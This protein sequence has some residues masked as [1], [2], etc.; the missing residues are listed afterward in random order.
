MV[1]LKKLIITLF[2][3]CVVLYYMFTSLY[4]LVKG[5]VTESSNTVIGYGSL[6]TN[7]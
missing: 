4:T 1:D 6:F 2:A 7:V 5:I 3:L